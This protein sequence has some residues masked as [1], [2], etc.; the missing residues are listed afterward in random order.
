MIPY[1]IEKTHQGE[2]IYDIYSRLLKDRIVFLGSV[3]DDYIANIIIAQ[4]LFLEADNK[5]ADIN[6]YI[7]SAGGSINAGLSIYDTMQYIKPNIQTICVGKAYNIA[8]VLL[9]SGTQGKRAALQHSSILLQQPF[10][11]IGGQASDIKIQMEEIQ[12]TKQNIINIIA[13]HTH[14]T[15]VTINK[16]CERYCYL[17]S[18]EALDYGIIDKIMANKNV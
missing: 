2:R 9:S 13:R 16:D 6:F 1:V 8:A 5:E 3:I 14:K 18:T 12:R 10:S 17:N 11:D 7:N 4:F 15:K